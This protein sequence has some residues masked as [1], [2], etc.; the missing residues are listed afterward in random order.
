LESR[1]RAV[2]RRAACAIVRM[3]HK[4]VASAHLD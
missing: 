2:S 4:K 3:A 1:S